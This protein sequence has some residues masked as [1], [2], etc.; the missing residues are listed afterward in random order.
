MY[1]F[2]L[3]LGLNNVNDADF[4][5]WGSRAPVY[6]YAHR[7]G[8]VGPAGSTPIQYTL[9]NIQLPSIRY[10]DADGL[11]SLNP[12]WSTSYCYGP[13]LFNVIN[14]HFNDLAESQALG[15]QYDAQLRADV[16]A[17][18][19]ANPN[20]IY[21]QGPPTPPPAWWNGTGPNYTTTYQGVDSNDGQQYVFNSADAYGWLEPNHTCYA[22][23]VAVPDVA[24]AETY[25]SIIALAARQI[26]AA[27]VLVEPP[28]GT[29]GRDPSQPLMFQKEISSNGNTNTVDVMFPAMP[30]FLYSNPDLL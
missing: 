21:S 10:L 3:G 29:T 4:R 12:W 9:G 25:Y 24:E 6:A 19:Q 16:A 30:F 26:T 8:S 7:L 20:M 11:V 1:N 15:A 17:Y 23:G 5:G 27:Y 22:N 13:D 18:Y 14:F 2:T 28:N